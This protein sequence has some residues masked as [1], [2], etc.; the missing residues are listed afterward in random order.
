MY[1]ITLFLIWF[2]KYIWQI[3]KYRKA[4]HHPRYHLS[5]PVLEVH[6]DFG[7]I[8]IKNKKIDEDKWNSDISYKEWEKP[9]NLIGFLVDILLMRYGDKSIQWGNKRKSYDCPV[10]IKFWFVEKI[11]TDIEERYHW[12]DR[13]K[14]K[15]YKSTSDDTWHE[16][17]PSNS[18]KIVRILDAFC[19]F[20]LNSRD[21]GCKKEKGEKSCKVKQ[22]VWHRLDS[23]ISRR[24]YRKVKYYSIYYWQYHK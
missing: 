5:W 1:S 12:S 11:M 13:D 18:R 19:L 22:K 20:A 21:I 17:Y 3:P 6:E 4:Y 9:V 2:R 7:T 14:S 15:R 23:P 16:K 10:S 8:S 24:V